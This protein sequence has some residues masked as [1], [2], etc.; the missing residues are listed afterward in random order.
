MLFVANVV[1]NVVAIAI[2]LAEAI[3]AAADG[4]K[5][6]VPV[7]FVGDVAAGF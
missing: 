1:A 7:I 3:F 2:V 6:G 5:V 4:V